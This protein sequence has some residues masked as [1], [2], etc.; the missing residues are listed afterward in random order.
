[1]A[2]AMME[3]FSHCFFPRKCLTDQ[4]KQFMGD[5]KQE[6][7]Q[8]LQIEKIQMSLYYIHTN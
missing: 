3:I 2:A 1:M 6:L 7:C 5:L 8:R 4:G